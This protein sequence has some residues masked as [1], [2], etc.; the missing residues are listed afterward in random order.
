MGGLKTHVQPDVPFAVCRIR[1]SGH[2]GLSFSMVCSVPVAAEGGTDPRT[3][4]L[5]FFIRLLLHM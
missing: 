4:H 1:L 2:L 5:P 3:G